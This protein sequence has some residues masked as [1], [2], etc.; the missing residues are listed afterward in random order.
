MSYG[1]STKAHRF[2]GGR[3][4]AEAFGTVEPYTTAAPVCWRQLDDAQRHLR[5]LDLNWSVRVNLSE[6]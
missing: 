3:D 5:Q 2:R 4:V 1:H 6:A